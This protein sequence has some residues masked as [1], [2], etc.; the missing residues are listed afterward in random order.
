[1]A[2]EVLALMSFFTSYEWLKLKTTSW[3]RHQLDDSGEKVGGPKMGQMGLHL[4]LQQ[5][6]KRGDGRFPMLLVKSSFWY[7]G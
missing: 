5:L 6:V 2:Q 7:F 3:L 1:M 4:G